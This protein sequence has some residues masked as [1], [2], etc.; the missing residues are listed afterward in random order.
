MNPPFEE[1]QDIDHVQF[2]YENLDNGGKMAAIMSEGPFFRSDRNSTNFREWLEKVGGRSIILPAGTF[3][4]SG[5]MVNT[6][7]VIIEK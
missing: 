4:E 2:A 3:K 1:G 7:M 6:R 5:T